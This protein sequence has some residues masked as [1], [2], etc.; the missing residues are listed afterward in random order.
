[1]KKFYNYW[2]SMVLLMQHLTLT[3]IPMTSLNHTIGN[4]KNTDDQPQPH[5][6]PQLLQA[7][8]DNLWTP[9][10]NCRACEWGWF[11]SCQ[12]Q[13]GGQSVRLLEGQSYVASSGLSDQVHAGN[14]AHSSWTQNDCDFMAGHTLEEGRFRL[15]TLWT[16]WCFAFGYFKKIG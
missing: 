15:N 12:R 11:V 8:F 4:D 16:I 6:R 7:S 1:M 2:K 9:A 14:A 10:T 5:K 3:R 13:V